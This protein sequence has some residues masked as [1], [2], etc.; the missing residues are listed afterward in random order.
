MM[1][2]AIYGGVNAAV[3]TAMNADLSVDLFMRHMTN[4]R[5]FCGTA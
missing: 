5:I 3:L 1:K 4:S 2:N